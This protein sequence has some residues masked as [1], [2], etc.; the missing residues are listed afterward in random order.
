[1]PPHGDISVHKSSFAE[2]TLLLKV[3]PERIDK[4]TIRPDSVSK[5]NFSTEM[6]YLKANATLHN[7]NYTLI[8]QLKGMPGYFSGKDPQKLCRGKQEKDP[9]WES[10][11]S[12]PAPYGY[13][14]H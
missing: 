8:H 9:Y 12:Y 14:G 1:M 5:L 4:L 11:Q 7:Y 3:L 6:G 13:W 10:K 2:Q